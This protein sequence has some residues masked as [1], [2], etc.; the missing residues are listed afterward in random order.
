[1]RQ[2]IESQLDEQI[3]THSMEHGDVCLLFVNT[4]KTSIIC[5]Q[6]EDVYYLLLT[7]RRLS[8]V[9]IMET[10]IICWLRTSFICYQQGNIFYSLIIITTRGRLLFVINMRTSF[11][12]YQ[13]EDISHLLSTRRNFLTVIWKGI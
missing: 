2:R 9:I 5:Y 6:Q 1:M 7:S 11:I 8:F 4:K 13:N 12:C 10:S 3:S